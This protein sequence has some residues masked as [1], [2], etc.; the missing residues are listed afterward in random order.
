MNKDSVSTK[1]L[2]RRDVLLGA[3]ATATTLCIG[4]LAGKAWARHFGI[5]SDISWAGYKAKEAS[6]EEASKAMASRS[7]VTRKSISS[8]APDSDEMM[9][10]RDAVGVMRARSESDPLHPTGWLSQAATHSLYGA[11][12]VSGMQVHWSW[13]FLPW[14]RAYILYLERTMAAAIG[15]PSFALPYW[16]VSGDQMIP[17]QYGQKGNPLSDTTR[18]QQP[19]TRVPSVFMDMEA[20]LSPKDFNTFGGH[21]YLNDTTQ[22]TEGVMENTYHNCVHNW[23]GGNFGSAHFIYSNA[24]VDPLYTGHHANMDRIWAAWAAMPG[25]ENPDNKRWLD[26]VFSFD[27]WRGGR[28]KISIRDLLD[29][30][31]LGYKY[32]TL[33]IVQPNIE[34]PTYQNNATTFAVK[35]AKDRIIANQLNT[36]RRYVTMK[37]SQQQA[38][39][40]WAPLHVFMGAEGE[41]PE[42]VS[43]VAL[44]WNNNPSKQERNRKIAIQTAISDKLAKLLESGEPIETHFEYLPIEGVPPVPIQGPFPIKKVEF[45]LHTA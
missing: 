14:S 26:T 2:T 30:E 37:F 21:P 15:E 32:D 22:F 39:F 31:A 42:Y 8:L 36:G 3:G 28:D 13:L 4:G 40:H 33:D 23:V 20:C 19:G 27:N 35:P 7:V 38:P 25:H 17:V 5:E 34:P 16:D 45:K 6:E 41:T 10:F 18:V 44:L 1:K 43:T 12:T 29:T 24:A 11:S 9:M